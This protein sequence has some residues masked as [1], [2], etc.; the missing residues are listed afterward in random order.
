M[1]MTKQEIFDVIVK[2][3]RQVIPELEAHAFRLDDALEA[4]GA[5]SMDRAEIAMLTLEELNLNLPRIALHK[6]NNLRQLVDTFYEN[7]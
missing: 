2:H 7:L 6:A 5:N 1:N 3:S 4:L